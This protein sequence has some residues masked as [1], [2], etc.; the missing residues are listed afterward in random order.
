MKRTLIITLAL[1]LALGTAAMAETVPTEAAAVASTEEVVQEQATAGETDDSEASV[2]FED[3]LKALRD[4][5]QEARQD[6]LKTELDG[7]VATGKLT[8]EQADVILKQF[9]DKTD[10]KQGQKHNRRGDRQR[11]H[12][13][14]QNGKQG[15][16]QM[17]KQDDQ[18]MPQG[19]QLP[20]QGGQQIPDANSSATPQMPG[21]GQQEQQPRMG[22][23][24]MPGN[25][26]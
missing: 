12:G 2:T 20:Q 7:Y 3:A 26:R 14:Q 13:W 6:E 9:S 19:G 4:A 23:Q 10:Q 18:R 1:A 17:P 5:R 16:N 15:G 8:Q 24:Q 21:N 11:G 25:H 22:G